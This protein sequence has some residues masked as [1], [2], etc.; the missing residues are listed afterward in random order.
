MPSYEVFQSSPDQFN[1]TF[2]LPPSDNCVVDFTRNGG[3][4]FR[5]AGT[6]VDLSQVKT[7]RIRRESFPWIHYFGL[8]GMLVA[9][10]IYRFTKTSDWIQLS[11]LLT[12]ALLGPLIMYPYMTRKWVVVTFHNPCSNKEEV[13]Y[14]HSKV[15]IGWP[16]EGGNEELMWKL[17]NWAQ[18]RNKPKKKAPRKSK[19]SPRKQ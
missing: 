15:G 4:E 18:E 12:F 1:N 6:L 13:L 3:L 8:V 2:R 11:I 10:A 16:G 19:K 5:K 17:R 14:L 9:F 7:A